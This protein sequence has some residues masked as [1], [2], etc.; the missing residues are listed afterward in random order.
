M[1]IERV[2]HCD[3]RDCEGHQRTAAPRPPQTFLSVTEGG[4]NALHFCSWDCI[5]HHA[6]EKPPVEVVGSDA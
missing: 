6:A 5:L 2:Y 3:W 1:S 4:R